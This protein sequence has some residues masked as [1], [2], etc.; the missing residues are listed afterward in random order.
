M[1]LKEAMTKADALR[2]NMI[3]DDQKA[4]WIYELEGK[5][6]E[7]MD[8]LTPENAFPGDA[9]LLT[10]PPYDNIYELY[11][12]AMIDY[13]HEESALYAN[14]MA[15]FNT[16]LAEARAWWRREHRPKSGGSWEVM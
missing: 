6:A 1:Y 11:L 8:V 12:A 5:I 15:M 7:M 10:P 13:Y 4:A 2:P 9:Q 14:D 3:S 16:A